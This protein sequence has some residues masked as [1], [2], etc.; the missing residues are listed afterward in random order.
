ML[1]TPDT[2]KM[3]DDGKIHHALLDPKWKSG[4]CE[5]DGTQHIFLIIE[6]PLYGA[7]TSLLPAI[8]A[9]KLATSLINSSDTVAN[10]RR[11]Q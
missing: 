3:P 5:L 11:V 7:I 2:Y 1:K 6:H 8:E 4:I 10:A 9:S